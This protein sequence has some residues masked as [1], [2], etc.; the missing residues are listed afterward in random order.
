MPYRSLP[1]D[2]AWMLDAGLGVLVPS[3]SIMPIA[4]R[5]GYVGA[6]LNVRFERSTAAM[7]G[8]GTVMVLAALVRLSITG[9][10]RTRRPVERGRNILRHVVL[11]TITAGT[12]S[13]A[14]MG[15]NIEALICN[16]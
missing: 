2:V 13:L 16:S 14:L 4:G 6:E 8:L 11:S 7:I 15:S 5:C 12:H 10:R 9:A 3:A 1:Q